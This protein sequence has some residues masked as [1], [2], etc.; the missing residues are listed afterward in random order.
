MIKQNEFKAVVWAGDL[1]ADFLRNSSHSRTVQEAV[2]EVD[3]VVVWNTHPIDFTHTYE[4]EGSTFISTLDHFCISEQLSA[5]VLDAG[6]IRHPDNNSDHEPVYCVLQSITLS[7]SF[8]QTVTSKPRPSWKN[9]SKEEK[10]IYKFLLE[11]KLEATIIPTEISECKNL[12][13]KKS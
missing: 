1:N 12:H 8:S 4:R 5:K 10:D 11:R 7:L 3:L 6:V 9:A 2:E 13:C